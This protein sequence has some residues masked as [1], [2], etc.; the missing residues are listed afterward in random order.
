[1]TY[2]LAIGDRSYSSWSLRGWLMFARFGIPATLRTARLYTPDFPRL[3]ADFGVARTAPALAI[4]AD[5]RRIVLW[6]T[7]AMAETLAERH[8][9]AGLWPADPARRAAARTVAAEMH[10]GFHALRRACPM[11][12][13]RAYAGFDP[14]ADVRADL[15]RIEAL[16]AWARAA[17]GEGPWLLGAYSL[18][19]VFFAPVAARVATYRLPVGPE[20]AA[21]V[22][23]HLADP[24]FRAWR[25]A[26]AAE[27]HVQAGYGFDLPERP[28]PG[29]PPLPAR[30][31]AGVD[32]VNA[33]CPFSGDPVA[34]DSLA[35]VDGVVVG[36][37][38]RFC[39]DKVVADPEAWP[40]A[41][42]VVRA[43]R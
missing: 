29:P 32:P 30:A 31:V 16:W 24:S 36:F 42:A 15:A 11:N 6:D 41:M 27:G 35:E 23:A 12:L 43:P 37:C 38:N 8:P 5:G 9:D 39:R 22:A 20:A 4:E 7:L 40:A 19:D 17:A 2:V 34:P 18:A 28:W 33:A 3:L 14:S 13:R 21:Y 10:A 26:G 25:A 1:M